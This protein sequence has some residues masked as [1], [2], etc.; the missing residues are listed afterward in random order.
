MENLP[1][2]V[3]SRFGTRDTAIYEEIHRLSRH[4]WDKSD[5]KSQD[6]VQRCE[7]SWLKTTPL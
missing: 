3:L 2:S 5:V 7:S 4:A 6:K 1:E